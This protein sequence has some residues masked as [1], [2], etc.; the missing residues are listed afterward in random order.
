MMNTSRIFISPF[1]PAALVSGAER[2]S[3]YG[4]IVRV[5]PEQGVL[6]NGRA[7]EKLG[8][9]IVVMDTPEIRV[10]ARRVGR[11]TLCVSIERTESH[12]MS[13][14]ERTAWT[15][16]QRA[17]PYAPEQDIA[18]AKPT[19]ESTRAYRERVSRK[20]EQGRYAQERVRLPR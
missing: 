7:P 9:S 13:C 16:V 18:P 5:S 6:I 1:R 8:A 10:S 11:A 15:T 12:S 3:Q 4:I 2:L 19:Y 20:K 14:A 17:I